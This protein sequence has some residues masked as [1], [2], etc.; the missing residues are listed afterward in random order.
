YPKIIPLLEKISERAGSPVVAV[1]MSWE[2]PG[3]WIYPDCFP[4]A[5]GDQSLKEF[6]KQSGERRWH[7]GSFCNG[8]RWVTQHFWSGYEGRGFFQAEQG[9]KTVCRTH[10]QQSWAE[11]WDRTWRPSY[12]CCLGVSKTREIAFNFVR[13]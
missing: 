4:P 10:D 1:I 3:P 11:T 2:R 9:E 5:G 8:T 7:V 13:R 6:T 12:A